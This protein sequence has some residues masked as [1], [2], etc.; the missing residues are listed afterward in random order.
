MKKEPGGKNG[1]V[2][3]VVG[4]DGICLAFGT[5][6]LV[7]RFILGVDGKPS[8]GKAFVVNE[9]NNK[10]AYVVTKTIHSCYCCCE[11]F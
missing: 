8:R 5:V 11:K 7:I 9:K 3:G 1:A 6:I 2:G 4:G 10:N